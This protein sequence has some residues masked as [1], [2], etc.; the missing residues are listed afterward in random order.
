ML[1]LPA[2][3]LGSGSGCSRALC[4]QIPT[5][6]EP[7]PLGCSQHSWREGGLKRAAKS[8][9][10]R[11]PAENHLPEDNFLFSIAL[12]DLSASFNHQCALDSFSSVLALPWGVAQVLMKLN[13]PGGGSACPRAVAPAPAPRWAPAAPQE[14]PSPVPVPALHPCTHC[15][16]ECQKLLWLGKWRGLAVGFSVTCTCVTVT[17]G[18]PVI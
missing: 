11:T 12:W 9:P 7:Q 3:V 4:P 2:H 16:R 14:G 1:S 10:C 8:N 15:S 13:S 18:C 17:Q 6:P 5:L